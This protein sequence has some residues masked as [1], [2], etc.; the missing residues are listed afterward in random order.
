MAAS[1]RKETFRCQCPLDGIINRNTVCFIPFRI[2]HLPD[3]ESVVIIS[4]K[5]ILEKEKTKMQGQ[6]NEQQAG[7]ETLK[8]CD[9]TD[10]YAYRIIKVDW[11]QV[12]QRDE[13][14]RS[15]S[16]A[17]WGHHTNAIF[18]SCLTF[19]IAIIEIQKNRCDR[20]IIGF[21]DSFQRGFI[22]I[23]IMNICHWEMESH[24]R[25]DVESC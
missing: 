25:L 5:H 17:M 7:S 8:G 24:A 13:S 22:V 4:A 18:G 11:A 20:L 16:Y 15:L 9:K 6:T 10:H 2:K 23:R 3:F 12:L 19:I 1:V 21:V 14:R